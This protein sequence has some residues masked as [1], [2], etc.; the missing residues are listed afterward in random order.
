MFKEMG[1]TPPYHFPH[2]AAW[3]LDVMAVAPAVI[4]DYEDKTY[5]LV[6]EGGCRR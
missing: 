5:T 2:P 6:G 4:L 3:N 1:H